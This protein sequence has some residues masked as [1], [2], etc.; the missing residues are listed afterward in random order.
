MVRVLV[1]V[2]LVGLV[3]QAIGMVIQDGNK[4]ITIDATTANMFL[5]GVTNGLA[6][7]TDQPPPDIL[8]RHQWEWGEIYFSLSD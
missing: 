5:N 1:W 6:H 7:P 8:V 2:L 3:S 4:T